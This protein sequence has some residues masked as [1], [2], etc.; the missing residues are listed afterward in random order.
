MSK[1]NALYH[2]VFATRKRENTITNEFR[3][4]V[5]RF[6]WNLLKENKCILLRISGVE[7]H[8]H[9][10][11]N[12]HPTVALSDLMREIKSKSS[13][14]L[15]RDARFPH[16]EG[17]G[18][19]YFA[20]TIAYKERMPVIEYIKSQQEHHKVTDFEKELS[21]LYGVENMELYEDT[22]K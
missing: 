12:L 4:D 10:L 1:V 3:D 19:E 6:I 18:Q 20:A 15:R 14:W 13:G 21:W 5:Y 11:I 2:I 7:N 16:F 22:L 17:W 9:M 8:I